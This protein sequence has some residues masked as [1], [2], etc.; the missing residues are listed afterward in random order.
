MYQC[1][2]NLK[3]IISGFSQA[4]PPKFSELMS[5]INVAIGKKESLAILFSTKAHL[6]GF[7]DS[8]QQTNQF[9]GENKLANEMIYLLHP[10]SQTQGLKCDRVVIVADFPHKPILN[11]FIGIESSNAVLLHYPGEDTKIARDMKGA[12]EFYNYNFNHK[13]RKG[14]IERI[15]KGLPPSKASIT[16]IAYLALCCITSLLHKTGRGNNFEF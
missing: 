7:C 10:F 3:Q 9:L 11:S 13:M 5:E 6:N 12:Y 14:E 2:S 15:E 1:V 4:N 8:I 16:S